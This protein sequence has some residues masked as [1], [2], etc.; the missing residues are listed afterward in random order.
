MTWKWGCLNKKKKFVGGGGVGG[1]HRDDE[2]KEAVIWGHC[3]MSLKLG[4]F[5]RKFQ[6]C[7]PIYWSPD[8]CE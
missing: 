8:G 7:C 1:G 2:E 5:T 3:W 6:D 4:I